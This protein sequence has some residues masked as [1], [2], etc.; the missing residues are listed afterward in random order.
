MSIQVCVLRALRQGK[1]IKFYKKYIY[2]IKITGVINKGTDGCVSL[3]SG[4]AN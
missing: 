4:R 1:S 2:L 3:L